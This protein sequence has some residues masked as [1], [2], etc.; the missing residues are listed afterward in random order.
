[1][2]DRFTPIKGEGVSLHYV[3][4][5]LVSEAWSGKYPD[6]L[7]MR[8]VWWDIGNAGVAGA[9]SNM[10]VSNIKEQHCAFERDDGRNLLRL[11]TFFLGWVTVA[12]EVLGNDPNILPADM[13]RGMHTALQLKKVVTEDDFAK[14]LRRKSRLGKFL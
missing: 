12:R 10:S 2:V 3:P 7:T 9:G 6:V 4:P 1:M 8:L 14:A 13:F 5:S 11:E